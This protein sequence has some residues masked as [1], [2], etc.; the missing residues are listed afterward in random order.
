MLQRRRH[1]LQ[2]RAVEISVVD[3][4]QCLT[5]QE[6]GD[7]A[8]AE[9]GQ[10]GLRTATLDRGEQLAAIAGYQYDLDAAHRLERFEIGLLLCRLPAAAAAGDDEF[11]AALQAAVARRLLRRRPEIGRASW[12]ERGCQ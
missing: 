4:L 3:L 8:G 7:H 10:V 1:A 5:P 6:A 12:R 9:I 2:R 11:A